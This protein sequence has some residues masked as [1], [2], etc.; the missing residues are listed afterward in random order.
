M[1]LLLLLTVQIGMVAAHTK[2]LDGYQVLQFNFTKAEHLKRARDL[3]GDEV[4]YWREPSLRL[5]T[6]VMLSPELARI[7]IRAF[8]EIGVKH[9]VIN[10]DVQRSLDFLEREQAHHRSRR[11]TATLDERVVGTFPSYVDMMAW[12]DELA[13]RFP[14]LVTVENIGV[15]FEGRTMK[16]IKIGDKAYPNKLKV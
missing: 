12:V 16:N 13:T 3:L 9:Q 15:S 1:W 14:N 4:D 10:Q 2:G 6:E 7:A 8:D 11:S 5:P